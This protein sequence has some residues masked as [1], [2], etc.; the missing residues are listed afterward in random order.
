[1]LNCFDIVVQQKGHLTHK[2]PSLLS[3]N[4]LV[5]GTSWTWCYS[6]KE[7][8]LFKNWSKNCIVL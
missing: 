3:S 2:N 6:D 1:M 4:V 5:W 8:W 7:G